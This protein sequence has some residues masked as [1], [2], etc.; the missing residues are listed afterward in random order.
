MKQKAVVVCRG[1]QVSHT[2]EARRASRRVAAPAV[3]LLSMLRDSR[4]C[5]I[6]LLPSQGE[7]D[8]GPGTDRKL[9]VLEAGV[10]QTAVKGVAV[11]PTFAFTSDPQKRKTRGAPCGDGISGISLAARIN[12]IC[13][14]RRVRSHPLGLSTV[15]FGFPFGPLTDTEPPSK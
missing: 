10:A 13:F 7:R 9:A 3:L 12:N 4:A 15:P 2:V 1:R 6:D 8:Q 5:R 14:C 11:T